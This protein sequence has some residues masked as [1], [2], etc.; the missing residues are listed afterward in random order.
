MISCISL[1]RMIDADAD[2]K[3]DFE[4]DRTVRI[5]RAAALQFALYYHRLKILSPY[6]LPPEQ[7]AIIACNHLNGIDPFFVQ[8][9]CPRLITWMM[10]QEYYAL[11]GVKWFC[12][13]IHAIPVERTGKDL[14]AT[15]AAL[16]ALKDGRVLG[17]FPEGKVETGL[18]IMPFQV[19]IALLAIKSG[20]PVVPAYLEGT[21]RG[22]EMLPAFLYPNEARLRFGEP[23]HFGEEERSMEAVTRKIQQAVKDLREL[24]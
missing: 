12:G 1:A 20:R 19:G 24:G 10:A 14:A 21:Q 18:D 23:M 3:I 15:R 11:P 16:R 13:K 9:A 22:L 7:P 8:A 4:S 2:K 5:G 17:V 6:P